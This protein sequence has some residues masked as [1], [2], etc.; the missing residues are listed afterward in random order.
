M[1][2]A[3]AILNTIF[4]P[5]VSSIIIEYVMISKAQVRRNKNCINYTIEA[6]K[7]SYKIFELKS[8][9]NFIQIYFDLRACRRK[10]LKRRR[11]CN[12]SEIV[13]SRYYKIAKR[14][15]C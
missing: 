13:L 3:F 6:I 10:Y 14:R 12:H 5:D 2:N 8:E 7:D 4:Y 15:G 9:H 11:N 1:K